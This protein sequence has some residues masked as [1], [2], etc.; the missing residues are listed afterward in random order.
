MHRISEC[1]RK[2]IEQEMIEAGFQLLR[3]GGLRNVNIDIIVE[4]CG[5][6]KGSFYSFFP[7]KTE[8]IHA[9]MIHKRNQ[10]KQKLREY[11]HDGKLS[12]EALYQY[13]LWLANSDLDI[14]A[15]MSEAER[16]YLKEKWPESYFNNDRN[17]I[18]TVSLVLR[19]IASPQRNADV[20]LFANYLK[21]IA[22]A[23]AERR[24]FAA[25]AFDP[26]INSLVRMACA[27]IS[28]DAGAV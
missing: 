25:P 1:R 14:F 15:H 3:E 12:F 28:T 4:K 8:F 27:C 5:I 13:L 19:H 16:Q 22:L 6:S 9:I 17:N 11:L 18:D 10:A 24:V 7:G 2:S 26:M 20:L 23:K 21:M